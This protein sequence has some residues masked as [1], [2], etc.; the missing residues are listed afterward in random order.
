LPPVD[1]E[2]VVPFPVELDWPRLIAARGFRLDLD[3]VFV[4]H[5]KGKSANTLRVGFP[6]AM[7]Q[8]LAQGDTVG[9]CPGQGLI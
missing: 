4:C 8:H 9:F 2:K 7:E 3:Q 1:D 5:G 6:D